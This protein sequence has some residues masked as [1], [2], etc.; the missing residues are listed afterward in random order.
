MDEQLVRGELILRKITKS[1]RTR[2]PA[3]SPSI[4]LRSRRRPR[5]SSFRPRERFSRHAFSSFSSLLSFCLLSYVRRT[6]SWS[7]RS[8]V[9]E[10]LVRWRQE[11]SS[12]SRPRLFERTT[13]IRAYVEEL[14]SLEIE[15]RGTRREY[16]AILVRRFL[17]DVLRAR[18]ESLLSDWKR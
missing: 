16:F 17:R 8:L 7:R 2:F 11:S 10:K 3:I 6:G 13:I 12:T 9:E 4:D 15:S 5:S 1:D 18:C 14:N